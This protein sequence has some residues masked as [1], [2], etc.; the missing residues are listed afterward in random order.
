[1]REV[2]D[3][4]QFKRFA[5]ATAVNRVGFSFFVQY[6]DKLDFSFTDESLDEYYVHYTEDGWEPD[7]FN[8]A[9]QYVDDSGIQEAMERA[10]K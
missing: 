1:M 4:D 2:N 6:C 10:T 5:V 3:K 8:L 7:P 9:E